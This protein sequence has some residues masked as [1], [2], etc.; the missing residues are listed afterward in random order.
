MDKKV[1]LSGP[2]FQPAINDCSEST[3]CEK[4]YNRTLNC[5]EPKSGGHYN[6]YS[7]KT[8]MAMVQLRRI[9]PEGIA[10]ELNFILF[11]TSGVHGTYNTIEDAEKV[12]TTA[13]VDLDKN[14]YYLSE[15]TFVIIQP[16]L[17]TI[18]YGNCEPKNIKDIEFLKSLRQSSWDAVLT[19]GAIE[20]E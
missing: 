2:M 15:V 1:I 12:L 5:F 3:K 16:R 19:I 17:C 13:P 20:G 11:S 6:H 9:F 18:H 4:A 10:N 14:D 7:V 8:E